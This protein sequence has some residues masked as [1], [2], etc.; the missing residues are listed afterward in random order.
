MTSPAHD[1]LRAPGSRSLDANV[2]LVDQLLNA[3]AAEFRKARSEVE[4]EPPA[5]VFRGSGEAAQDD[6][7][8][9]EGF[10]GARTRALLAWLPPRK[11]SK[12]IRAA[13]TVIAESAR[14]KAGQRKLPARNSRKSVTPPWSSRSSRFPAAPPA[15]NAIPHLA[16]ALCRRAPRNSSHTSSRITAAELSDQQEQR[17]TW[18]AVSENR[19]KAMPAFRLWTR[20]AKLGTSSRR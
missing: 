15:I 11:S 8:F 5:G 14:L 13:P 12:I 1:A 2:A 7:R 9:G 10:A 4:V 6:L 20:S 17:S 3:R 16:L 19:P 18:K